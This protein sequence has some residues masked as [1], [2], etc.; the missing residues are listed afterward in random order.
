MQTNRLNVLLPR[1]A[2]QRGLD[3]VAQ[4]ELPDIYY[5]LG[6]QDEDT[7]ATAFADYLARI[8]G[9]SDTR[10]LNDCLAIA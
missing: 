4:A 2:L 8:Y 7:F 5:A 3:F 10:H 6:R 9:T 1:L